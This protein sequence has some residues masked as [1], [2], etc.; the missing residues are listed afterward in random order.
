M[1]WFV[2]WPSV[3]LVVLLVACSRGNT[4]AVVGNPPTV[5]ITSHSSGQLV[6][7][8]NRNITVSGTGSGIVTV[9]VKLNGTALP[10]S[11]VTS[12]ASSFTASLALANNSNTIEAVATNPDGSASSSVVTVVYP[13]VTLTSFQRA[14]VVIGQP[15]FT[16]AGFNGL[17]ANT[18]QYPVGK[19]LVS[20]GKL[21]L[22]DTS[23]SRVLV[24]G[25]VPTTDGAAADMVLGQPD[26]TTSSFSFPAS[27]VQF[28]MPGTAA[29]DSGKLLVGDRDNNRVVIF[30]SIPTSSGAAA[31]VVV[32]QDDFT[33]RVI[34]CAANRLDGPQIFAVNGKLLVA[35]NNR[36]LVWNAIPTANGASADLVLGQADFTHCYANQLGAAS[37]ITLREPTDVWSDG[38]RLVV[39][40]ATNSRVL[41]WNTFP[42]SSDAPADVVV[43]QGGMTSTVFA[44][45][46]TGL[47]R[48][49]FVSS[50]GNQLFVAD[51]EN[52]RVL[53]WNTFP[54]ANGAGADVVL[55]QGD[56][57]HGTEND[58]NQDGAVDAAP[59]ARTLYSPRGV[60]V[61]GN[62]LFVTDGGNNRYLVFNGQ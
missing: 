22:P 36:V 20:N 17:A 18:V 7:N 32:G 53:V 14:S 37:A 29:V 58:D 19:A 11:A 47:G 9:Q 4:P 50:N 16:G 59:T 40:D 30:N 62:Q 57:I 52:N 54:T 34:G 55:G 26:F 15:D 23:N 31:D 51:S 27:A 45:T 6:T 12:T 56:F 8:G 25:S 61:W 41:I 24:Y 46:R 33:T 2:R 48:P 1:S 43:G 38:T 21:Y 3:A 39:A 35:D 5:Q 28:Y 44:T 13:F 10:A 60:A 49:E 42:T